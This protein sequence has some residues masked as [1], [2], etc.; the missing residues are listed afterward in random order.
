MGDLLTNVKEIILKVLEFLKSKKGKTVGIA[1]LVLLLFSGGLIINASN[2]DTNLEN[3][4]NNENNLEDL[5]IGVIAV[6]ILGEVRNPG[7]YYMNENDRVSDVIRVSGGLTNKGTTEGVNIAIKV[8]DGLKVYIP[9]K[10]DN[11]ITL[12]SL[13]TCSDEILEELLTDII[14]STKAKAVVKYRKNNG[15]FSSVEDILKVS[16]I[17]ESVYSKVKEYLIL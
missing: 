16:G 5:G 3:V 4:V 12:I 11:S 7:I 6:E 14:G 1:F 8:S 15:Y 2:K 17:T 10:N 13:N 9:K